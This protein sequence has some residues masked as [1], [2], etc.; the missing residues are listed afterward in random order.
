[1]SMSFFFLLATCGLAGGVELH[2]GVVDSVMRFNKHWFHGHLEHEVEEW[3]WTLDNDLLNQ[4]VYVRAAYEPEAFLGEDVDGY[5]ALVPGKPFKGNVKIAQTTGGYFFYVDNR[6]I[7]HKMDGTI[8]RCAT[9]NNM[10]SLWTVQRVSRGYLIRSSS[11]KPYTCHAE[12]VTATPGR[13]HENLD[14]QTCTGRPAQIFQIVRY[15]DLREPR[16]IKMSPAFLS[17]KRSVQGF[18]Y[19]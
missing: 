7:C 2:A 8:Q 13:L 12:C 3:Q 19:N 10:T 6:Q 1:M 4:N 18:G 16:Y 9:G 5:I 17:V 15:A 11:A 14:L